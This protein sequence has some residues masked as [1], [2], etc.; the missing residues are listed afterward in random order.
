MASLA[1]FP[2]IRPKY[3]SHEAQFLCDVNEGHHIQKIFIGQTPDRLRNVLPNRR[4]PRELLRAS[5]TRIFYSLIMQ[6]HVVGEASVLLR[7]LGRSSMT[8]E[9][10][11]ATVPR[12]FRLVIRHLPE[13]LGTR[14][15]SGPTTRGLQ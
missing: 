8:R 1:Q 10:D 2:V 11:H 3:L 9:S 12:G 7:P 4:L 14:P 6:C 15:L 5:R 13:P